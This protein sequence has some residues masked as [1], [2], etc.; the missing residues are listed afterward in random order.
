[1]QKIEKKEVKEF[2]KSVALDYKKKWY[3]KI[4]ESLLLA[5]ILAF[6]LCMKDYLYKFLLDKPFRNFEVAKG[7]LDLTYSEN[8]GA[9]FGI[10]SESTIGLIVVTILVITAIVIYLNLNHKESELLR[11]PLIMIVGG[12]IGNLVDRI[13]LGYVRDFFEFTFMKFAIFNIADAF[14]TVGAIWL[15]IYLI[16]VMV[17]EAKK[18]KKKLNEEKSKNNN[19]EDENSNNKSKFDI[20]EIKDKNKE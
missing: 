5:G 10:L 19:L 4:L 14:V 12:G 17:D 7:F 8:T 9:G 18:S 15:V 2:F 16:C 20:E 6:D 1:M 11:I 13:A 3:W